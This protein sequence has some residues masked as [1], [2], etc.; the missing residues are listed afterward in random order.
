MVRHAKSS[1]DNPFLRDFDRPLNERG[2][3]NA[4]LMAARMA[5]S[6]FR[7]DL[8]VSSP[9]NRA[10]ST[11]HFF[12]NAWKIK[13]ANIIQDKNLFHASPGE[14]AKVIRNTAG[15]AK[16]VAIFG[17]NPGFTDFANLIGNYYFENIVTCGVAVF[18]LQIE[19]W[20]AL[21]ENCGKLLLYDYP[22]KSEG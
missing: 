16:S 6:N 21:S 10:I 8:I 14:I 11:A 20:T 22:K 7:P 3:K 1:W 12:A 15:D 18:E 13:A 17:H 5:K 9:A 19:E 2:K 4:P